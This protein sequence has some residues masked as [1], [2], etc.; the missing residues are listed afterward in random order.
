MPKPW[1]IVSSERLIDD[2]WLHLRADTCI[3]GAGRMIAPYYIHESAD[4]ISVFAID[5]DGCAV[6][7]DEYRPTGVARR[8]RALMSRAHERAANE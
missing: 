2:R 3:D 1:A 8:A 6:V 4:W 5:E 7:L